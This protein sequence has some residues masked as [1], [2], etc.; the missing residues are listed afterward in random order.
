MSFNDV[1]ERIKSG[2]TANIDILHDKREDV[3]FVPTRSVFSENGKQFVKKIEGE[4]TI[5]WEVTTGLRGSDGRTEIIE[6]LSEG[7]RIAT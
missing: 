1:D 6:G 3:L 7:D 5:D 2:L 4:E